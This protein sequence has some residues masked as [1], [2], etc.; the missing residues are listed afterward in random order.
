[1]VEVRPG[2]ID[3]TEIFAGNEE[4]SGKGKGDN[5]GGDQCR[6]KAGHG[7]VGLLFGLAN[8][9]TLFLVQLARCIVT[10]VVVV[11]RTVEDIVGDCDATMARA[12]EDEGR[13][14]R[15]RCTVEKRMYYV[16]LRRIYVGERVPLH[17][18]Q[19]NR[20]GRRA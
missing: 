12:L 1:M 19:I 8:F 20:I 7:A 17:G 4:S 15:V 16:V 2:R 11:K 6:H 5:G 13:C 18:R 14:T 9:T 3:P 10:G